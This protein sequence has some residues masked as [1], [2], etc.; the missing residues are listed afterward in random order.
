MRGLG[1]GR[2]NESNTGEVIIMS[3]ERLDG[4]AAAVGLD[5]ADRKH[6]V[7]LQV[8]G[9]SEREFSVLEHKPEAIDDWA[10]DLRRRFDDRPVAVC[11]ETRRGPSINVPSK[12]EHLVLYP[13]N[14]N[15]LAGLRKA[16]ASSGAKDDP[17]S[18]AGYSLSP[19]PLFHR[20]AQ[21]LARCRSSA[22]RNWATTAP[23]P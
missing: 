7:C 14:P 15:L 9:S 10:N 19:A 11:L 17:Q 23:T 18:G 13:I 8:A 5:W 20:W 6:D 12:Y 16:F 1:R 21:S 22:S 3:S 2:F 4:F